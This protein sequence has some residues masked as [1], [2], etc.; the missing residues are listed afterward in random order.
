MERFTELSGPPL[1]VFQ[2]LDDPHGAATFGEVMCTTYQAFGAVGL[3]SGG[4]GRDIDQVRAL[5]FPVFTDGTIC[6]HGY[7]HIP[8]I[9]VPVHV[10]GLV[11]QPNDLLHGDRNGVTSIPTEIAAEVADMSPRFVAAEEILLD[12][13]KGSGD[14]SVA[15]YDELRR[16]F[17]NVVAGLRNEVTRAGG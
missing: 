4:A 7:F 8:L 6:S 10:G 15:R 3:V 17:M 14:K 9:H 12:Y 2:D 5:N 13:V 16:E 11:V 1:V